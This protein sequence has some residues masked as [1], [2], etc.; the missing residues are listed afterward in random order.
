[1]SAF[2]LL[3]WQA[4]QDISRGLLRWLHLLIPGYRPGKAR[5]RPMRPASRPAIRQIFSRR[6]VP[7][8]L[9]LSPNRQMRSAC[10]RPKDLLAA[11]NRARKERALSN[12]LVREIASRC[13][14]ILARA[15]L[16]RHARDH[17]GAAYRAGE[18]QFAPCP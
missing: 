18:E 1:M 4:K 5:A 8:P 17:A 14:T 2:L 16:G 6:P 13:A 15:K 3:Q 10:R 11:R 9:P 12:R 7:Q